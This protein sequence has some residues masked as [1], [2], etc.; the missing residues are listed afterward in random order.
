MNRFDFSL[1]LPCYNEGP[2]FEDSVGRIIKSLAGFNYEIIFVEDKSTDDTCQKVQKFEKA[3]KNSR[4][5]FHKKNVGRGK[6]VSD[7]IK[8]ARANICGFMDV[9]C[10][11]SPSYVPLFVKEIKSGTDLAI[12]KRFYEKGWKTIGRVIASKVYSK[13]VKLLLRLPFDDTEAGFKFF[14]RV[15][16][17]KVLSDT[18]DTGWFWDTEVCARSYYYDLKISDVPVLFV[19]RLD[20]KSTV[21]LISD[22]AGYFIKIIKFRAYIA[23]HELK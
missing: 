9:D 21:N 14:N 23:K 18:H 20:K 17:I 1:I 11:I 19:R 7:G 5:I 3:L 6:S 10:E 8:A 22:S 2:T 13:I 16:I 15:K 12:G 4:A